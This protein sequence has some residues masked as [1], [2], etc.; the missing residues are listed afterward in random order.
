VKPYRI[1]LHCSDSPNGGDVTIKEIREW[2]L[3]RG[4]KDVGYHLVILPSGEIQN[5]RYLNEDGAHVEG[6]NQGNIGICLVGKDKFTSA[7]WAALRGRLDTLVMGFD[8][9]KD[10][11]FSHAQ[12]DT[13]IKQGKTC[14]NVPINSILAW[15]FL[16][17]EKFIRPYT[18]ERAL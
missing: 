10:K 4:F 17:D 6:H 13:A 2:H 5:G 15:Y 16:G 18:L 14:P 7:Q 11:I 8:I 12:W 9:E 3:A 1:T